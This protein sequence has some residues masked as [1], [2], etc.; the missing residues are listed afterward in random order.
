MERK[1]CEKH[2]VGDRAGTA[3]GQRMA[4]G[5]NQRQCPRCRHKWSYEQ[6]YQQWEVLKAVALGAKAHHAVRTLRM[7]VSAR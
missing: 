1:D 5:K 6:R 2:L 4:A 3:M 7:S